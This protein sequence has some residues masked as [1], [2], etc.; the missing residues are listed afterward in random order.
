MESLTSTHERF[1]S[2]GCKLSREVVSLWCTRDLST[3]NP[4]D[5][6]ASTNRPSDHLLGESSYLTY[7]LCKCLLLEQWRLQWVSLAGVVSG[8]KSPRGEFCYSN[9]VVTVIPCNFFLLPIVVYKA[10]SELLNISHC[11]TRHVSNQRLLCESASSCPPLH[12][13]LTL[14]PTEKQGFGLE[15]LHSRQIPILST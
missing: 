1:C 15:V 5:H 3:G 12:H 11:G 4:K 2:A 10:R 8:H 13:R 14:V 6:H 7:C 9:H